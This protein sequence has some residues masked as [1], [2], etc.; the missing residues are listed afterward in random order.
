MVKKQKPDIVITKGNH[1]FITTITSTGERSIKWD[2]DAL[3]AEVQEATK[4]VPVTEAKVKKTR[5]KKEKV[6]EEKPKRGRKKKAV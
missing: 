4:L 3:L 2:W 5:A 6:A 1:T